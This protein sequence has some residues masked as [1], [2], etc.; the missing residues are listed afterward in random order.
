[1]STIEKSIEV[2]VPVHTAYN[3]WTQFEDF[4]CFM[5]G[6]ERV[7]QIG[8]KDLQW[9]VNIGGRQKEF[10]TEITEQLPDQRIAWRTRGGTDNSGV[11]TFHRV[12]EGVTRIMLQMEYEPEGLVEKAGDLLG[13]ASRRV[14]GD[15][16][17]FKAFIEHTGTETGAWRGTI[18]N[19]TIPLN[20]QQQRN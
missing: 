20:N 19:P 15:L 8:D 9:C 11:V 5:E 13:V 12:S 6:V 10:E 14:Q 17:R 2:N 7:T 3:Q 16:D 18:R 1:M 4:P